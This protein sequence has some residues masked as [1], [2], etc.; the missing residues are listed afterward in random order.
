MSILIGICGF[1][2]SGKD[3]TA[4]ILT[5]HY[6]FNKLSFASALKDVIAILFNWSREKLEGITPEDRAWREC[7][8]PWWSSALGVPHFSPRRALEQFGDIFRGSFHEQIFVCALERKLIDLM[9]QNK[10]IVITDCRFENE[11][12]LIKKY[13]GKIVHIYREPMPSWFF[14]IANYDENDNLNMNTNNPS[15]NLTW[16]ESCELLT[17]HVSETKWMR[18]KPDFILSNNSS[19]TDF[20]QQIHTF[21]TNHIS[22]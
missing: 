19:I 6:G 2:S 1:K 3:T 11:I 15:S 16:T 7:V 10:N 9:Q 20:E 14:K 8:D 22:I 18:Q 5:N 21:I 12:Q 4:H 17:M 13:G